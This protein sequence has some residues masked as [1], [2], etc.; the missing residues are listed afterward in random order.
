LVGCYDKDSTGNSISSFA[1]YRGYNAN[2]GGSGTFVCYGATPYS[3]DSTKRRA[4]GDASRRNM[5]VLRREK[6]SSTLRIYTSANADANLSLNTTISESLS[7][8]L[9]T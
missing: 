3:N 8:S 2:N 9:A 5:I 7:I 4:V 6:G 1:L